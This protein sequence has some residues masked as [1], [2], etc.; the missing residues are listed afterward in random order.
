[1]VP[2]GPLRPEL[3]DPAGRVVSEPTSWNIQDG[4]GW[5]GGTGMGKG[6]GTESVGTGTS[7]T[8]VRDD[9]EMKLLGILDSG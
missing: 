3:V 2:P 6:V 8:V 1:M 9:F 5:G 4:S 7:C